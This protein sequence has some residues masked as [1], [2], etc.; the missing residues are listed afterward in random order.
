MVTGVNI[1]ADSVKATLGPKGRNVVIGRKAG[2]PNITKDGVT[3]ARNVFLEDIFQDMGAQMVKEAAVRACE[4]AG[5]GTTTATVIAQALI[6]TG[7]KSVNN[8]SNPLEVKR[9][10]DT[11]VTRAIEL[12][13]EKAVL[14]DS[15]ESVR[16]IANISAN[17]DAELAE[18]ITEAMWRVGVDGVVDVKE[19][20][21]YQDD[22]RFVDGVVVERGYVS[23]FFLR[24]GEN[25]VFMKEPAVIIINGEMNDSNLDTVSY[26]HL[27]LPTT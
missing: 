19:A 7:V 6:N 10:I 12:L 24:D 1:L 5:D 22:V 20:T 23:P 27:T 15:K 4:S 26:T 13:K 3:V 8:G 9:G 17:G 14:C 21:G 18:L 2:A 16:D 25:E 11:V